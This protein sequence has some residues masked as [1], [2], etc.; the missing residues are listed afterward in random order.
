MFWTN[1]VWKTKRLFKWLKVSKLRDCVLGVQSISLFRFLLKKRRECSVKT[2]D[3]VCAVCGGHVLKVWFAFTEC[4]RF[5]SH[6]NSFVAGAILIKTEIPSFFLKPRTIYRS[7]SNDGNVDKMETMWGCKLGDLFV[8][9][10]ER[11]R[12]WKSCYGNNSKGDK[13]LFLLWCTFVVVPSFKNTASRPST[14]TTN[15]N[16]ALFNHATLRSASAR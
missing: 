14:T 3:D 7:Q 2:H 10:A 1:S 13:I 6:D 9:F 8:F 5:Y 12:S 16:N 15:N 4:W 11:D